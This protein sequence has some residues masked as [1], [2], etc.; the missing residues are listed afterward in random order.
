MLSPVRSPCRW[1]AHGQTRQAGAACASIGGN[2]RAHASSGAANSSFVP[3]GAVSP[4]AVG[5]GHG[6]QLALRVEQHGGALRTMR[7]AILAFQE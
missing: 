6:Q 2:F 7:A 4:M 3:A 1:R 5:Q